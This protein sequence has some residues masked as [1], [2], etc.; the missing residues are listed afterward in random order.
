[1]S[2][3]A[4]SSTPPARAQLK[5]EVAVVSRVV[6]ARVTVMSKLGTGVPLDIPQFA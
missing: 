5:V 4:A 2:G 3:R 1:M 6:R